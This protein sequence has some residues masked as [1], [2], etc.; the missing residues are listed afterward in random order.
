MKKDR[1]GNDKGVGGWGLCPQR[2]LVLLQMK[3]EG[4]RLEVRT[5]REPALLKNTH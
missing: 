2:W 4:L 1:T 5:F 3:L